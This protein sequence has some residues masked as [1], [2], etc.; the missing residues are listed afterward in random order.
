[1]GAIAAETLQIEVRET[2]GIRRFGYPVAVKLPALSIG[3]EKM[4]FRL[5]DGGEPVPAQF[6]QEVADGPGAWWLDFNL[7]MA[8]NELRT[9]TIE[10]GPDVDAD[11][12][13]RGLELKQTAE[14]FEVRNGSF[15][16]WSVGRDLASL[17]KSVGFPP[18]VTAATSPPSMLSPLTVRIS[19]P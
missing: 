15:I 14:G 6:R 3:D 17:L 8:P 10:Y 9:V 4:R 12:E 13:P 2:A 5:R 16:T 18:Q 11:A 7:S 1:M 19:K